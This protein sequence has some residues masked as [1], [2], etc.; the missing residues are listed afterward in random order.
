VEL[1]HLVG[2][3]MKK[4]K[5]FVFL[6]RGLDVLGIRNVFMSSRRLLYGKKCC[7]CVRCW[8]LGGDKLRSYWFKVYEV[9]AVP[10]ICCTEISLTCEENDGKPERGKATGASNRV[11]CGGSLDCSVGPHSHTSNFSCMQSRNRQS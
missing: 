5:R 7:S 9:M 11:F 4:C 6:A 10:F 1:V 2:F 3:I 8:R